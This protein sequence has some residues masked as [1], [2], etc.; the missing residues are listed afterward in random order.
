MFE[1][2]K[3]NEEINLKLCLEKDKISEIS[4]K[5]LNSTDNK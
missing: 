2:K 5:D 4:L 1:L 3:E